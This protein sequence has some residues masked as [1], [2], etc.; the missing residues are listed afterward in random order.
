MAIYFEIFKG[1]QLSPKVDIV[2]FIL[3]VLSTRLSFIA[4]RAGEKIN[5]TDT[6][7]PALALGERL[8]IYHRGNASILVIIFSLSILGYKCMCFD[9]R[10]RCGNCCLSII[11][12]FAEIALF[13]TFLLIDV[14]FGGQPDVLL[15]QIRGIL[16][17]RGANQTL[18]I[19][20]LTLLL[21]SAISSLV[22][23]FLLCCST[24]PLNRVNGQ[25]G[26][27][28]ELDRLH[29]FFAPFIKCYKGYKSVSFA[30]KQVQ[31][32]LPSDKGSIFGFFKKLRAEDEA[33][34]ELE[35]ENQE[36]SKSQQQEED[37]RDGNGA[38]SKE[39]DE[40]GSLEG[41]NA[42]E[43]L[44]EDAQGEKVASSKRKMK[45]Y[46]KSFIK[47]F[48]SITK[49]IK[50]QVDN[51]GDSLRKRV[52][53]DDPCES[54]YSTLGLQE[55][56]KLADTG[57]SPGE[58][59]RKVDKIA[60]TK[61]KDDVSTIESDE[62]SKSKNNKYKIKIIKKKDKSPQA[63]KDVQSNEEKPDDTTISDKEEDLENEDN[64]ELSATKIK[65]SKKEKGK[66][67][68]LKSL[69]K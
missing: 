19:I 34:R 50:K 60:T 38:E 62:K 11:F 53:R 35:Y 43:E 31:R 40:Q 15:V 23:P 52:S 26:Q 66:K 45:K 42:D 10:S 33:N 28:Y 9:R 2:A 51:L 56:I 29:L 61:L 47:H 63:Q 6:E 54:K 32:L 64:K 5:I 68:G 69:F 39:G 36:R 57:L 49:S 7:G 17:S 24:P 12:L 20:M 21:A 44:E 67:K 59:T 13:A 55:L 16:A 48:K 41:E 4:V 46:Q 18:M 58:K 37:E 1:I 30:A 14:F 25:S 27:Q 65:P 8:R 22:V 3:I